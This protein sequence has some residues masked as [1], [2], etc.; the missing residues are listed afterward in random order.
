MKPPG[1]LLIGFQ[2]QP[3]LGLGYLAARL[4]Q[5]GW[6][7]EILDFRAGREAILREVRAKQPLIVGFS[8]I[9]QYYLPQFAELAT[10]LRNNDVACHFCAGG[11]FPSLR[12]AE[13]LRAVPA[14][15]SIVRGEG[16]LTLVEL[17]QCLAEGGDWHR[18]AGIAY[19]SRGECVASMPRPLIEDLDQLPYPIRQTEDPPILGKKVTTLLA[20]RGCARN[21]SFCSIRQFYGQMPGRKV[22]L[23]D[24][25]KVAAEVRL[26]HEERGIS[27]FLF[28]D[29]DFPIRGPA[30]RRWVEKF[31]RAM[32]E[33]GLVGKTLWKISCR[34]DEV[35]PG[36][37]A[38]L[39]EAGL[40]MVYLGLE[41]GNEIG[42]RTL[43]KGLKVRDS[44][45][46]VEILHNL[47]IFCWYGFMLF[48]P[49]STFETVRLNVAFLRQV[50]GDGS[51]A[52]HFCRMV[53][54]ASTPIEEQLAA[55]GRL[56]GGVVNPDYDFLDSRMSSFFSAIHEAT[57]TWLRGE[58]A[59]EDKLAW[60]W[61][62]YWVL[63]RLFPPIAGL[64]SYRQ[65]LTSITAR[66]NEYLLDLV[67]SAAAAFASGQ[68]ACPSSGQ[69]SAVANEFST[70]LIAMRDAFMLRNQ[71][72]LLEALGI[73][74]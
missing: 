16:E 27:V 43:N 31:V 24:P 73:A 29:D 46:A 28:Q 6:G 49:S 74:A 64:E 7:A 63:R 40:Y 15:D 18:I 26:L 70:E 17:I 60:A 35:Q 38:E 45:R 71:P 34:A 25:A 44:L 12:P 36:L 9:F 30:G 21:C 32:S 3:N 66:A 58:D 65:T 4:L 68:R 52:A 23:R 10:Y 47:E 22:R 59:L 67:E 41:S 13:T 69:V 50:A 61:H 54:Y 72:A 33:E 57:G 62:E 39:R 2:D 19:R 51:T 42:L 5:Q 20:S 55:T 1:A 48:D 11:H 14:L 37:F 8:L 53:P 56:R